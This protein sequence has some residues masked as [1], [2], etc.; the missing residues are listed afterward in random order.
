[1]TWRSW[2]PSPHW[3]GLVD[4][5]VLDVPV[6]GVAKSGWGLDQFRDY[7]AASLRDNGMD[8]DS[9]AARRCWACSATSTATS[10]TTPPMPPCRG[11]WATGGRALFYLEVPPVAVRPH[12]RRASPKAGRAEGARVMVEKPF[13]TD[14]RQRPGAQRDHAR[15]LRRGRHLPGRPLARA[16]PAGER[17]GRPVRQLRDRAAAEPRPRDEH[18]D[19]HGRGVRRRRPRPVLRPHRRDP[20]RRAEPHAAGAGQRASPTRRTAPGPSRG[21]TTSRG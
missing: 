16:G 8:P 6:I 2:R 13:G 17:A 5:G 15:G 12:R 21:W 1:M 14:L 4:R 3:S 9:P 19:H 11:R 7:A 18:P 20:R 10:T